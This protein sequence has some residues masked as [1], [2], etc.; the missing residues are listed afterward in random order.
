MLHGK[1]VAGTGDAAIAN[2]TASIGPMKRIVLAIGLV[3]LL[4]IPRSTS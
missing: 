2:A 3:T 4:K 1:Q